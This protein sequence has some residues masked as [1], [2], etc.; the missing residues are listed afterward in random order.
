MNRKWISSL[1]VVVGMLILLFIL[2]TTH[3]DFQQALERAEYKMSHLVLIS[4]CA[5][6]F[7]VLIEWKALGRIIFEKRIKIN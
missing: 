1:A 5:F 3:S 6:L 7:G 4:L 2:A